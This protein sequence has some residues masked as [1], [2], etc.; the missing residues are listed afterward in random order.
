MARSMRAR[1]LETRTARLKLPIRKKPDWLKIG[2]GVAL[3]YRRNQGPGTWSVR[4]ADGKSSHWIKA[5][6]TA[7]DYDTGELRTCP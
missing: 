1:R 7:D 6:A 5:I 4:V 3:G 2:L